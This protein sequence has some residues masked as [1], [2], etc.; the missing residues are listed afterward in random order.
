MSTFYEK[1]TLTNVWDILN[2]K[3][4]IVPQSAVRSITVDA[5]VDTGAWTLVINEEIRAALG[6]TINYS[7]SST[8]A[9]G[10]TAEYAMTEPV[11][12]C[13]KDRK[14]ALPA[15]VIPTADKVLFGAL[16]ME[17]LDVMA[18]PV[19]E[20]LK[21]RHGDKPLHILYMLRHEG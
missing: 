12:F 9:D 6:L 3:R 21:G 17:S 11:E 19:D 4:G 13:W 1:I 14:Y 8:Q 5:C 18:D 20:C 10:T 7:R 2:E 15:L 16:P